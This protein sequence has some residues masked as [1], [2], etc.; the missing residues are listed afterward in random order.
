MQG[1]P[2]YRAADHLG[3]LLRTLFLCDK[4]RAWKSFDWSALNRLYEQGFI[5]D[6]VSRAKSVGL[7]EE[8]MRE[9]QRLFTKYFVRPVS[10]QPAGLPM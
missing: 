4:N 6:P 7:T 8:G 2:A 10:S 9:A 1:H 5:R 3:R